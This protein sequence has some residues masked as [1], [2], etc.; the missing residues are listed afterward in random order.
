MISICTT[1]YREPENLEV[2]VRSMVGNAS[3]PDFEIIIVDDENSTTEKLL[4]LQKEFP[5]IKI[6]PHP[7]EERIKF[8]QSLIDFYRHEKIFS[9]EEIGKMEKT[10]KKYKKTDMELWLPMPHNYNLASEQATGE[11]L[12]FMPADYF[13][14]FDIFELEKGHFE[15]IDITSIDPYPDFEEL[16]KTHKTHEEIQAL[17]KVIL[18]QALAQ[19]VTVVTRQ[20]GSR[21]VSRE[22]FI[23]N[24]KFDDKWFV[25]A[26]G[27]DLFN[28][29]HGGV[30]QMPGTVFFNTNPYIGA[31]RAKNP[32]NHNYLSPDYDSNPDKHLP[33]LNKIKEYL[34]AA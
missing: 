28:Q 23:E 4:E 20:H 30:M 13:I 12:I 25:R 10:L 11:T 32:R 14:F 16:F 17:S 26:F 34:Y 8:I 22:N 19:E 7:K 9:E 15:W 24:G 2:F 1:I 6:V 5:Q 29:T 21:V 27:D 33:F 3:Q 18:D 31:I